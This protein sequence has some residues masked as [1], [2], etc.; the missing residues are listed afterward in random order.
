MD[1]HDIARVLFV[2]QA[3]GVRIPVMRC[4]KDLFFFFVHL[5]VEG[6][7]QKF[8]V[9]LDIRVFCD[10]DPPRVAALNAC[11]SVLGVTCHVRWEPAARGAPQQ[12]IFTEVFGMAEDLALH[13]Y[14]FHLTTQSS[15]TVRVSF[16]VGFPGAALAS[17]GAAAC[18]FPYA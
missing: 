3:D 18:T 13:E 11:L 10:L 12:L 8:G 9:P 7:H 16:S 14:S 4:S 15:R 5:V 1:I 17:C 2:T 6:A